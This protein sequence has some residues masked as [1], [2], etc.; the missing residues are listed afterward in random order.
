VNRKRR[1]VSDRDHNSDDEKVVAGQRDRCSPTPCR[2]KGSVPDSGLTTRAIATSRFR[3]HAPPPAPQ[4]HLRSIFDISAKK[5]KP[6]ET[7]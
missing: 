6:S 4:V 7:S 5:P 3:R 2:W 1:D